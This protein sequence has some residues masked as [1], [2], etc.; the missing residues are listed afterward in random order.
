MTSSLPS[1]PTSFIGRSAN[2]ASC[3]ARGVLP[4]TPMIV[5]LFVALGVGMSY[6]MF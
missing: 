5:L 1:Q 3:A 6:A 2:L 4:R